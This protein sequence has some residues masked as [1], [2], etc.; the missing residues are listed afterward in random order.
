MIPSPA[1][2]WPSP[3]CKGPTETQKEIETGGQRATT[4]PSSRQPFNTGRTRS[5][6]AARSRRP[7]RTGRDG[8]S[9][10]PP[11]RPQ[12]PGDDRAIKR[13]E[14]VEAHHREDLNAIT[15]G[16]RLAQQRHRERLS[17][18]GYQNGLAGVRNINR[19]PW[20]ANLR[21]QSGHSGPLVGECPGTPSV[22]DETRSQAPSP[23]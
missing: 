7:R 12:L 4:L 18:D 17:G 21:G 1:R 5:A 22:R 6:T 14:L 23:L 10:S 11:A 20:L 15:G 19:S 13:C 16:R 8:P 2:V 9:A 3:K